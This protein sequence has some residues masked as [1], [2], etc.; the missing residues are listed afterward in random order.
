MPFPRERRDWKW[1][2]RERFLLSAWSASTAPGAGDQRPQT[3][4]NVRAPYREHFAAGFSSEVGNRLYRMRAE[5][6][7]KYDAAPRAAARP[8]R[9]ATARL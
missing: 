6:E 7:G 8:W 3:Y 5:S 1:A 4:T 2:C 9:S